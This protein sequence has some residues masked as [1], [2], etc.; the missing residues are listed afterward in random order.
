MSPGSEGFPKF[1]GPHTANKTTGDTF[2]PPPTPELVFGLSSLWHQS[3]HGATAFSSAFK[4]VLWDCQGG[5]RQFE[6]PSSFFDVFGGY[7]H[8]FYHTVTRGSG[9]LKVLS[10][11]MFSSLA[12][13][14]DRG[15]SRVPDKGSTTERQFQP[16]SPHMP[17]ILA[18]P[19]H[20]H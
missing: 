20:G 2:P 15:S 12:P 16:L 17:Y 1:Q 11:K 8:F 4:E 9:Y 14:Q 18:L 19:M 13:P 5:P 3:V 7:T 6:N 10:V